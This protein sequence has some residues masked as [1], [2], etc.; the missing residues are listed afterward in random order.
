LNDAF[1]VKV[2]RFS[3]KVYMLF[4]SERLFDY[5]E[6]REEMR[7]SKSSLTDMLF[8]GIGKI[9]LCKLQQNNMATWKELTAGTDQTIKYDPQEL[10]RLRALCYLQ[11]KKDLQIVITGYSSELLSHLYI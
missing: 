7:F 2:K 11:L 4:F 1:S 9:F 5:F 6:D 8:K 10:Y 3:W